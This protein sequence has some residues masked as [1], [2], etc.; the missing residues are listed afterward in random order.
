MMWRNEVIF[1]F[2]F[3]AKSFAIVCAVFSFLISLVSA[4]VRHGK[5]FLSMFY[6]S[7]LWMCVNST[8]QIPLSKLKDFA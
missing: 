8:G 5:G 7:L 6:I 3:N 1:A 2:A 4:F